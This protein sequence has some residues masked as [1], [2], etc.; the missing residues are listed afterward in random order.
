M[1]Y[2]QRYP[3]YFQLQV[4][5][6]LE[7]WSRGNLQTSTF[8]CLFFVIEMT[9]LRL[10]FKDQ[11]WESDITFLKEDHLNTFLKSYRS[12]EL[13]PLN[14][15]YLYKLEPP[16]QNTPP[17]PSYTYYIRQ[18]RIVINALNFFS[19]MLISFS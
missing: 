2:S 1:Y 3:F 14:D 6:E 4:L 16:R 17:P 5:Y 19:I 12:L 8:L 15:A 10:K 7:I 13:E 9:T 11:R 18:G